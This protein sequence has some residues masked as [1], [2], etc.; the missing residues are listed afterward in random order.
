MELYLSYNDIEAVE[1]ECF[2]NLNP[3]LLDLFLTHNKIFGV[4]PG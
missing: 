3:G 4:A 1:T 2:S